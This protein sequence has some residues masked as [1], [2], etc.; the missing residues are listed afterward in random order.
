MHKVNQW[1]EAR[2]K[3]RESF[4]DS[5]PSGVS[6]A[7]SHCRNVPGVQGGARAPV[8]LRDAAREGLVPLPGDN[9]SQSGDLHD[10]CSGNVKQATGSNEKN[11]ISITISYSNFFFCFV[12]SLRGTPR[13]ESQRMAI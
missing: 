8:N 5:P 11:N 2:G 4:D 1:T 7:G 3:D 13:N 6:I 12:F 9:S 10:F